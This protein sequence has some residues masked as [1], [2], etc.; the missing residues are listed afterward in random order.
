MVWL[1]VVVGINVVDIVVWDWARR[2][3][4]RRGWM[5]WGNDFIY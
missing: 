2:V 3:V 4:A 5:F 1:M